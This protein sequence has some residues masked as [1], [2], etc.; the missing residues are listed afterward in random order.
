M[1]AAATAAVVVGLLVLGSVLSWLFGPDTRD[2]D[3]GPR[4]SSPRDEFFGSRFP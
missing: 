2:P 4:P 1:T 3:F